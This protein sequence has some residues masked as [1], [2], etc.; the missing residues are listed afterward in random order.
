MPALRGQD[1]AR[2]AGLHTQRDTPTTGEAT[3]TCPLCDWTTIRPT[4]PPQYA[5]SAYWAHAM[6]AHNQLRA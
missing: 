1:I 2:A 6:Q 4:H 5:R 3:L